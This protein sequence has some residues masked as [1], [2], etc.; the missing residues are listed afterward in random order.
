MATRTGKQLVEAL[1]SC[2]GTKGKALVRTLVCTLVGHWACVLDYIRTRPESVDASVP[3][4]VWLT[5]RPM[6]SAWV[7]PWHRLASA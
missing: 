1:G 6:E 7:V 2:E 5:G 3:Q 4:W